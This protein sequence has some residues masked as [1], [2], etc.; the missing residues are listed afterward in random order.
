MRFPRSSIL[1]F[2]ALA[3]TWSH[4]ASA[5]EIEKVTSPGG[6]TAWLVQEHSVPV[7][8]FSFAFRA[9]AAMDPSGKEGLAEMVSSTLDEGAGDLKSQAFQSRLEDIS[10]SLRF[11]AGYDRFR[12]SLRTLSK[13]RDE[14]FRL[15]QL[16]I[17]KPRFDAKPVDRIRAQI[18]SGLRRDAQNPNWIAGNA[19]NRAVFPDHPYGRNSEGT[20]DTIA[21]LT[22]D[23]LRGFVARHMARGNVVISA[24]GDITADELSRRL[25]QVFGALPAKAKGV[26]IAETKSAVQG[27]TIVIKRRIPQSVVVFGHGGIKRADPDW[28]A[29]YVM[30]R[31]LGGGGFFSRLTEEVREKRGLAYSVYAYLYPFDR[32]GLIM[33]GVATANARVGESL[34]IIRAEW[35]RMAEKGVSE[36][37]LAAAKTYVNGSFP[38]RLDSNRRISNILLSI[39]LNRLGIDYLSRRAGLI[40]GVTRADIS[41]VASRLLKP[42]DLNVI[43]VGDPA[44]VI[45]SE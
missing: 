1:A 11:S 13:N 5:I 12:G 45:A 8:S 37:E 44:G 33:G 38:L 9:G 27:K 15:L 16:A 26:N 22:P 7:I 4:G 31:I 41:R 20:P 14:A 23:D 30:F 18:I 10:A 32:A 19:W 2:L 39:Q 29:A 35:R 42:N 21:T 40:N 36:T 17:T 24:V 3:L 43:V 34:K 28:Y 6:L 25:D